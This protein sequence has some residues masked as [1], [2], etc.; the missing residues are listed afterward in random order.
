[1]DWGIKRGKIINNFL[2]EIF[3]AVK[4]LGL[5]GFIYETL[6]KLLVSQEI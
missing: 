3:T 2:K 4:N 5:F 1:M 6:K